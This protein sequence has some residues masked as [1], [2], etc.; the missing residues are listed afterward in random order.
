MRARA[1]GSVVTFRSKDRLET[2]EACFLA[3]KENLPVEA[4]KHLWF[5]ANHAISHDVMNNTPLLKGA[6]LLHILVEI[7]EGEH[8]LIRQKMKE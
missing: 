5:Y 7:I 1:H 6:D 8:Y 3:S 2:G 4:R